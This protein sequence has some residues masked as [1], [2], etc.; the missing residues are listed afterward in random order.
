MNAQEK[1]YLWLDSFPLSLAEKRELLTRVGDAVTLVKRFENSKAFFAEKGKTELF[2][3]MA[4]T[5]L[6]KEY[7]ESIVSGLEQE[8]VTAIPFPHPLYP[9]VW[10]SFADA[11][12]CLYAKGNTELLRERIFTVVGSR[13]TPEQARKSCERVCKELSAYFCLVTGTA[14]GGDAAAVKGALDGTGRVICLHAGGL[15]SM[16]QTDPEL[17]RAV[18][19]RGLL[20]SPCPMDTGIRNFSFGYRNKLLAALGEGILVVGAGEKSGAL[21]TANHA[22]EA[23][24]KAFAFPYSIGATYG[25][26]CNSLIK[27]GAALCEDAGDI[28]EKFSLE[29]KVEKALTLT[30]TEEKVLAVL[31]ER[32]EGHAM[33][34]A[35]GAGLPPFKATTVLSSFEVKGLA[36]AL[37]GNRYAAV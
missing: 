23:G 16:P 1:C 7:F 8:G 3:K 10:K 33:E 15:R 29:R 36:V 24:K 22:L 34:I 18:E 2:E 4:R 9:E 13:R 6:G 21:L 25:V 31:K 28:L 12:L 37:G 17:Y 35:K 27:R 5:L 14:E 26:G 11:P 20:L 32:G 19:K 30:E